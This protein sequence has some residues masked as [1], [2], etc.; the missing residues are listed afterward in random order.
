LKKLISLLLAI[1]I[2]IMPIQDYSA[3]TFNNQVEGTKLFLNSVNSNKSINTY[4][5]QGWQI[6]EWQERVDPFN[7]SID[8]WVIGLT[9]SDLSMITFEKDGLITSFSFQLSD[10]CV[11]INE[12]LKLNE[13]YLLKILTKN[14]RKLRINF[15]TSSLPEIYDDGTRRVIKVPAMPEEGFYWPY[16]LALP[17][18]QYREENKNHKRYLVVDT[19]NTGVDNNFEYCLS[20]TE[21]AIT[22]MNQISIQ[23]AER[24]WAPMLMPV[25]PRPDVGYY[26]DNENNWIYTHALDRDTATLHLMMKDEQL[27]S[28]LTNQFK[29]AGFDVNHFIK[30]DEQLAAMT[31]HAI[32]YLNQY[33]NKI[34]NKIFLSGYS[35]SGTFVDRFANLHPELVKAVVSGATLDDMMLPLSEHKDKNLIFPIGTY[36]Y[37]DITGKDFDQ[38]EQNKVA[39]L[40]F[41]GEDDTNNVVPYSDCYGDKER[42]IIVDLWGMDVL[43]RAQELIKL[44]IEN[45]GNGIFILDKGIKHGYSSQMIDYMLE[46]LKANRDMEE[47][48]YPIPQNPEQLKYTLN[49]TNTNI[50]V[51]SVK[52]NKTSTSILT[53]EIE[54]LIAI[55]APESATNKILQWSSS[56]TNV[57]EVT[58]DGEIRGIS[59][60]TA[61]VTASS[62][63]GSGKSAKCTITVKNPVLVNKITLDNVNIFKGSTFTII[64]KISPSNAANKSVD[65]SSSDTKIATIDSDGLISAIAAGTT[66]ITAKAK[67][68][69]GKY[70]SCVVT[71]KNP[72]LISGIVLSD[73]S[74]SIGSS[75]KLSTKIS[76]SNA[77]NKTLEWLSSN[78]NVAIVD[79]N[80]IVTGVAAGTTTITAKAKDESGKNAQCTIT[81]SPVMISIITLSSISIIK[82]D[83]TTLVPKIS[84]ANA[85]SKELEWS[86]NNNEIAT[87][88]SGGTVKGI[89]AGTAKITAKAKDGSGK[90]STCTVTVKNP[91]LI[92]NIVLN[93]ASVMVGKTVKLIPNITPSN[94]TNKALEWL[95]SDTNIAEVDA[96]GLVRGVAKGTVTIT[97]TAADGSGKSA[98]CTVTVK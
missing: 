89:S 9:T 95:I 65:W 90:Y 91:I 35:A 48:E 77:T 46:F 4:N 51:T 60:G 1:C 12:E 10:S 25:F 30:L 32:K 72:V 73:I 57:L 26:N 93:N 79:Q 43:P 13:T 67:D 49:T 78:T 55:I 18:S 70:G 2:I 61:V 23:H 80:G 19:N 94:V 14:D 85:T 11:K 81:A 84:P 15:T 59:A 17:S 45:G 34:E 6:I 47:P 16:F 39:R 66:I 58:S 31:R 52:L 68:Q 53:G 86:S 41:M 75:A 87:V 38:G 29:N 54:K 62:T 33:G 3:A 56:N 69:S 20:K 24:L 74:I 97:V 27:G 92:S 8:L 37:K 44:Y 64:P 7:P 63:D 36:D 50:K 21:E 5:E 42:N 40:I 82:G 28:L 96:N 88:D 76:P 71:V 83:E 22:K 98:T